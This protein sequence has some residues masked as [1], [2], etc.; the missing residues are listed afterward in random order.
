MVIRLFPLAVSF[1]AGCSVAAAQD[2]AGHYLTEGTDTK[3]V[4]YTGTADITMT[5]ESDCRID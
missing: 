3:G 1:A 2:I 5:S 4:D